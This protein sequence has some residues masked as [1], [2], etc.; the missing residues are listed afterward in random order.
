MTLS[1][2]SLLGPYE[3]VAPL[4]AGGMGEVWR[5]RDARLSRE[6][7][8][9]VLPADVA[10]DPSRL[11]RF[12]KEAR[13]ASALNHPNIVTIYDIGSTDSVSYIAME[14]VAG[15]TLRELLLGGPMQVKKLIGIAAQIA[16]GLARAHESGIIHRDLKPENV[17][18]TKDGLVK[19]LDFGLAKQN[20]AIRGEESHLPTETGTSPGLILGTVGY[21][22]PE[23]AAGHP[24]DFR[25]DQFSLGA[26]VYEMATG[27]RAFQK[28][29]AVD[30]LSAIL[31]E[32]PEPIGQLNAQAP[33]PLR[34]VVERCL[35][36]EPRGRY[37]ST[38]DLAR[39]FLGVANHLSDDSVESLA[40]R[41]ARPRR[42]IE[43][44]LPWILVPAALAA[45]FFAAGVWNRPSSTVTRFKQVTFGNL[46]ISKARFAPDGQSVVYS[47]IRQSGVELRSSRIGSRESRSLDIPNVE[48]H[49]ISS[50]GDM[51]ITLSTNPLPTLARAAL[52][53]GPPREIL[54]NCPSASWSPDG[55]SLAVLHQ[56]GDKHRIEYPIGTVLYET[57][58]QIGGPLVSPA[59]DFV[60]FREGRA[61]AILG[62]A[63]SK[64][65]FLTT[66]GSSFAWSA[67]GQEIWFE[68]LK[69]GSTLLR[70]ITLGG[71]D[72]I[73]TSLP[74]DFAL[75]DIYRDG[76]LLVER[77]FERWQ[78]SGSFRG[79]KQ[80]QNLNFLDATLPADL[81][82]DGSTLLFSEKLPGW[83]HASVFK[84]K[85]DGSD[86]V[87]L[88]EGFGLALSPDGKWA[89]TMPEIPAAGL[90]LL[91]TGAGQP[92]PIPNLEKLAFTLGSWGGFHPAGKAV[93][94]SAAAPGREQR[95]YVQEIGGGNPRPVSSEG[96]RMGPWR[97]SISPDGRFVIGVRVR[98]RQK[99][100]FPLDGGEPRLL[101]VGPE[102]IVA[103]WSADRKSLYVYNEE[104][105]PTRI[106]L[107]NVSTGEKRPWKELDACGRSGDFL[108]SILF[109]PD[110]MS[111]VVTCHRW[112]SNLYVIE[113]L[114]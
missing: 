17:M 3:I 23:Q 4:G 6:V 50:A 58:N 96:F 25:S 87:H 16:D 8:I 14:L 65:K 109:T 107:L 40:P 37:Q 43:R 74:G 12:E 38:E 48:I 80:E 20:S 19:I 75:Q 32:E 64:K 29:T 66:E 73:V 56:V 26:I 91:P 72:R 61:L 27:R 45:G 70:A 106:S 36:K 31:N 42:T 30:T 51:A 95:I 1:T 28:K 52:A 111:R 55:K 82:A 53:G 94:F 5:A 60:A 99:W 86:P 54:E 11:K 114:K 110:G 77:G 112:L 22:S 44:A 113:G 47:V 21:M 108:Q 18:L 39:D 81:S 9:K 49:S 33:V 63:G 84:R 24:L 13:A 104:E 68:D 93:I 41:G 62:K 69:E 105:R 90:I 59:G 67:N 101:P 85:T 102:D 98:D 46:T 10:A 71:R 103:Q 57:K 79:E 89:L 83:G 35:A 92:M 76:R 15:K 88:G 97:N 2:G 78:V 34:W 7:A 100:L